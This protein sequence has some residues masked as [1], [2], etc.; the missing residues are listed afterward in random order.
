MD[1]Q[2]PTTQHR[3]LYSIS[4]DKPKK[5]AYVSITESPRGTAEIN[6]TL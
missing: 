2:V 1:E 5:N 6:T 4:C 3:E